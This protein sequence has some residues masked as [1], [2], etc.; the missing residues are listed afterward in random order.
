M[1]IRYKR[2]Y[3]IYILWKNMDQVNRMR[4]IFMTFVNGSLLNKKEK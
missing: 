2:N 3:N 4:Y 1:A